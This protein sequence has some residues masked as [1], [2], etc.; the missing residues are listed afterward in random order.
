M[1]SVLFISG[2]AFILT[3]LLLVVIQALRIKEARH[4]VVLANEF[5]LVFAT[6]KEI[7]KLEPTAFYESNLD[8][9]TIHRGWFDSD[10]K[11]A[12]VYSLKPNDITAL[13]LSM[14]PLLFAKACQGTLSDADTA[15]LGAECKKVLGVIF[16]ELIGHGSDR[17]AMNRPLEMVHL[18]WPSVTI[19]DDGQE[20]NPWKVVRHYWPDDATH[21]GLEHRAGP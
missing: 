20:Q 8:N 18:L 19:A 17:F 5:T 7:E 11:I 21:P 6:R 14:V 2:G 4:T 1:K 10:R 15:P 3:L 9:F 13:D 12:I 16:H